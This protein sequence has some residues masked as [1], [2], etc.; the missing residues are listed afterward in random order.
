MI[1]QLLSNHAASIAP[2]CEA[3]AVVILLQNGVYA[4]AKVV[5]KYPEIAV[6]ALHNDWHASGLV[7]N[8]KVTLISAQQWVELCALHHPV[9]TIQQGS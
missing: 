6:Y 8:V 7:D 5:H 3:N 2:Y 9:I 4:A 1:V